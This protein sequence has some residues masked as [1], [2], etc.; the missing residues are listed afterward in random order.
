MTRVG[1]WPYVER[2]TQYGQ[3]PGCCCHCVPIH[4]KCYAC[5]KWIAEQV[6]TMDEDAA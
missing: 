5:D 4:L 6:A 1:V 3:F 2:E